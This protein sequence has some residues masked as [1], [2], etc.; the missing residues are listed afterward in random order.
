MSFL[1][2][3]SN[4]V[5][6]CIKFLLTQPVTWIAHRFSSFPKQANVSAALDELYKNILNGDTR[7]GRLISIDPKLQSIIIFSDQHKGARNGSDD[8]QMAEKNYLAALSYY[9]ANQFMM[10]SLGDSEELWENT[11]LSVMK[12]YKNTFDAEALFASR[13]AF[14]KVYG[15]HDL[16]WDNDPFAGAFL[17]K[18]YGRQVDIYGGTVFRINLGGKELD[19]FCTHG[20]QGDAQSDGNAFSKWFVSYVWGPLQAY[21]Q[22]NTNK[23]SGNNELKTLHNE[24]MYQWSKQQ[25]NLILITGHTHQP[26]FKSLTHLERLY[27]QREEAIAA[28]NRQ[29]LEKIDAEIPRRRREYDHVKNSFR[30]LKPFYFNTGCC[31]YQDGNI[32]GIEISNGC[33]R[34]IKWN[35]EQRTLAEEE[36]LV[37][38]LSFPPKFLV[39]PK[40]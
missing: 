8:F 39:K 22:I 38:L 35:N 33:I 6:G 10:L 4:A 18:M 15:N 7:K 40:I 32:T 12:H 26:V 25:E 31:C 5:R 9:N 20:H 17:K 36:E 24:Y 34:L 14:F 37:Q 21:L 1:A 23:P 3:I 11:V 19:I 16:F 2:N 28:G 30:E 13:D 29:K 27:L